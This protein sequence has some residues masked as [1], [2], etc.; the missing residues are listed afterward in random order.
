M[1]RK[2]RSTLETRTARLKLSVAKT[3][4]RQDRTRTPGISLGYRRNQTAGTWVARLAD[5]KGGN[6]TKAIGSADD[7]SDADG[8]NVLDYWQALDAAKKLAGKGDD[9]KPVTVAE[10]LERYRQRHPCSLPHARR[11]R[12]QSGQAPNGSRAAAMA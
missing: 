4:L 1:A 11:H 8:R 12:R 7:Y 10:A 9:S 3:A 2:I 5:G 6:W